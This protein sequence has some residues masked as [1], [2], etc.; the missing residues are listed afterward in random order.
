MKP[1]LFI[2]SSVEG[3]SIAKALHLAMEHY[4]QVTL[5]TDNVFRPSSGTLASLVEVLERTDFAAFIVSDEDTA[6]SRGK[7]YR[8]PR[9]NVL[10]ELGLFAGK[11][12][13]ERTFIVYPR[14]SGIKMPTDLSGITLADFELNRSADLVACVRSASTKI[15]GAIE[16]LMKGSNQLS[17]QP[18]MTWTDLC[19]SIS[20]IGDQ[21]RRSPHANGYMPD[22]IFGISRGGIVVADLISRYLGGKIPIYSL[23]AD[24]F[25]TI[26]STS[27]EHD[28]KEIN[29][30][31]K[32]IAQADWVRNIL[33]VDDVSRN[34]KTLL[35]AK[36]LFR[37]LPPSKQMRV[38]AVAVHTGLSTKPDYWA[39]E[40]ENK[41]YR[42]C[43]SAL[44]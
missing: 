33:L 10:F 3:L 17:F 40:F 6:I 36:A 38:A 29:Q 26:G 19:A 4:A 42:L 5:W 44:G 16:G 20:R 43:F 31:A 39:L 18:D 32:L 13:I 21:L 12:G 27:F 14:N 25:T 11:I 15:E 8:A 22:V 37:T 30:A 24:R 23:W 28:A 34:G 35:A 2:G 9:D 1:R 7:K 41:S